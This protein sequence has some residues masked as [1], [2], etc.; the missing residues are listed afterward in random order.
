VYQLAATI[1]CNEA[2]TL[3]NAVTVLH[4]SLR[5]QHR[6]RTW[7]YLR[8]ANE[9]PIPTVYCAYRNTVNFSC[10]RQTAVK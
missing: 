6:P 7:L 10:T 8:K 5:P 3:K 4:I 2:K 9:Q 1:C